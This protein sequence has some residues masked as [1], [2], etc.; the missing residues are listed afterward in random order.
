LWFCFGVEFEGLLF[1]LVSFVLTFACLSNEREEMEDEVELEKVVQG[2]LSAMQL[3][4]EV[5]AGG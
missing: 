2:P 4:R 5:A 1:S 3:E